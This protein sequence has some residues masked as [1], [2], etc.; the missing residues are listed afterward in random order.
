MQSFTDTTISRQ[1][2]GMPEAQALLRLYLIRRR[3]V[4]R[5]VLTICLY[6]ATIFAYNSL[7][8]F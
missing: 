8:D 7:L 6:T 4:N 1:P 2:A 5:M 3:A